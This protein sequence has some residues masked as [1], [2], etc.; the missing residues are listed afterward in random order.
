M[1][2]VII[3]EVFGHWFNDWMANRYVAK[4][5]GCRFIIYLHQI[6]I[7]NTRLISFVSVFEPEVRLWTCYIGEILM[8]PGLI[9]VGQALENHAHWAVLG[10]AWGLYVCG[11]IIVSC[12]P[13]CLIFIEA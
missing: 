8:I 9:G 10:V 13:S 7:S 12:T 4:H 11:T 2:S 6:V 5:H 1:I 3:G